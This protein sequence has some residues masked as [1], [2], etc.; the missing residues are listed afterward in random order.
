MLPL[1]SSGTS[2]FV[3]EYSSNF[4]AGGTG[5]MLQVDGARGTSLL[6]AASLRTPTSMARDT[7]TGDVFVTEFSANRIVRVLIPR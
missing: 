2:A 6:M 4:L 7:R 3:L 5:R 1:N